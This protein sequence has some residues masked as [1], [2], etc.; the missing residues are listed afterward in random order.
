MR[1]KICYKKNC[2]LKYCNFSRTIYIISMC[3]RQ[4]I[5]FEQFKNSGHESWLVDYYMV[6]YVIIHN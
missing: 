3:L 1:V 4:V 5:Y 6:S 2:T